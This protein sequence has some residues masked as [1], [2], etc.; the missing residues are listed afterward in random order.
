MNDPCGHEMFVKC[1]EGL[2]CDHGSA[3]APHG[4]CGKFVSHLLKPLLYTVT[5]QMQAKDL[6]ANL[7]IS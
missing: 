7:S 6:Y 5:P 1:G 3:S 4:Y 2:K